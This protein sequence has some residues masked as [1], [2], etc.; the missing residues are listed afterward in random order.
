[1]A[2][3]NRAD[4]HIRVIVRMALAIKSALGSAWHDGQMPPTTARRPA[5]RSGSMM[6]SVAGRLTNREPQTEQSG[7]ARARWYRLSQESVASA[8]RWARGSLSS[9]SAINSS[10][11]PMLGTSLIKTTSNAPAFG[12]FALFRFCMVHPRQMAVVHV[13]LAKRIKIRHKPAARP[14]A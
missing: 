8:L 5:L 3:R 4:G 2:A 12:G 13:R 14:T 7:L 9:R 6:S 1:V 10:S 11:N